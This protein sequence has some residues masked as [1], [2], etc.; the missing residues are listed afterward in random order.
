MN[1]QI[2]DSHLIRDIKVES[3]FT[4]K[5]NKHNDDLPFEFELDINFVQPSSAVWELETVYIC[6]RR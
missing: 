1:G 4:S 5:D 3:S 2:L 6:F